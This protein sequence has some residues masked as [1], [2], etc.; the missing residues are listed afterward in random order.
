MP[1]Y[2]FLKPSFQKDQSPINSAQKANRF[3]V[4]MKLNIVTVLVIISSIL[5]IIG[6][7]ELQMGG[8]MHK[9]NYFHQKYVTQLV[10][11]VKA[12]ETD[13][14]SVNKVRKDIILVRE[15]PTQCVALVGDFELFM[16]QLIGTRSAV[17]VC[18]DDII[19]ANNLLH[20]IEKFENKELDKKTMTNLLNQGINAFEHNSVNFE[21]L[22][23]KTVEIFFFIVITTLIAKAFIVPI[24]GFLLSNSVARDYLL[25]LKTK[26]NLEK[27]KEKNA[28]IQSDRIESLTIMVAGM[29][30]E[31]NTPIGVSITANSYIE[32]QLSDLRKAYENEALTE[33]KF[34]NFIMQMESSNTIITNNLSRTATLI[35]SFKEVSVDQFID[36]LQ[37]IE[38]KSYIEQIL[39]SLAPIIK[40][41]NIT[42]QLSC[43]S[44]LKAYMYGGI[45]S[46]ILTNLVTNAINHAFQ[47][48]EGN[49]ISITVKP[50]S[51][52]EIILS[53]KDNGSGISDSDKVH[54]FDPFFTTKRGD[55]GSGLGLYILHNLVTDKLKGR[56]SCTSKINTG[57]QFDIHFPKTIEEEN[58][59]T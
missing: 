31:M 2:S 10:T 56:V 44:N 53:F 47:N 28:L 48:N 37:E 9:L 6:A 52:N 45:L 3:S 24:I 19:I 50:T 29:A 51:E 11:T 43:T 22:V 30:H 13:S 8:K 7:Y 12:F 16:M 34:D 1:L 27:E 33:D 35:K 49:T 42:L 57:T 26:T 41:S 36:E 25:L 15:Q 18:Q 54:I 38:L 46:Q 55:G 32:E 5:S 40:S 21:P 23:T 39:E 14:T 20:K 59:A 17:T 4:S 58:T